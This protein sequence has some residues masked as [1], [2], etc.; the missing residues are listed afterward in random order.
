M[1]DKGG[2]RRNVCLWTQTAVEI[3]EMLYRLESG[4]TAGSFKWGFHGREATGDED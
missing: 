3:K 4:G 1:T 2:R